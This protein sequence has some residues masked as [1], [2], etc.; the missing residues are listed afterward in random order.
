M[1]S[2]QGIFQTF[3]SSADFFSLKKIFK[4]YQLFGSK[5][6]LF[7]GL[8]NILRNVQNATVLGIFQT[9]CVFC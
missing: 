5:S 7:S 4:E 2:V 9:F 1:Y 8:L 3:L 6:T